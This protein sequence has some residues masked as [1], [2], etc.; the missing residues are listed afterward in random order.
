MEP[1]KKRYDKV[2][3]DRYY[4]VITLRI[5]S[6]LQSGDY[7]QDF[8]RLFAFG[9]MA[10]IVEE[11]VHKGTKICVRC[12]AREFHE[13]NFRSGGF[14]SR[15]AFILRELDVISYVDKPEY[16]E[17]YDENVFTQGLEETLESYLPGTSKISQTLSAKAASSLDF[18]EID[19]MMDMLNADSGLEGLGK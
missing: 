9:R 16:F 13:R 7:R 5:V 11:K 3:P 4:N 12:F 14:T 19:K 6:R 1:S 8:F 15:I 2:H 10:D 18:D 17:D